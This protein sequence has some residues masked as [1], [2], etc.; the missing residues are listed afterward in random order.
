MTAKYVK[1]E[2]VHPRAGGGPLLCFATK[3]ER[4]RAGCTRRGL[5][6]QS[7]PYEDC[8]HRGW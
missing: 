3:K 6:P 8:T 2:G 4:N 7:A 1:E 5:E